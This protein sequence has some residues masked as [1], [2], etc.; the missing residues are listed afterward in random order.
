M[1]VLLAIDALDTLGGSE[2]YAR[3][4]APVLAARGH[5]VR[6]LVEREPRAPADDNAQAHAQTPVQLFLSSERPQ[7][8]TGHELFDR[9]A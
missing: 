4:I 5:E 1:R 9:P 6:Y 3:E 8:K 7:I 2:R